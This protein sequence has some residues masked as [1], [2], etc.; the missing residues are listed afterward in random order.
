MDRT[1][2]NAIRFVMDECL[3]PLLRDSRWFMYPFYHL[4]YR[5][6]NVPQA[7]DFKTL[8][9]SWSQEEY[10]EFYASLDT[11]SRNRLTDLNR[12]S[13]ELIL[14]S[15]DPQARTL[16]DVGSGKG[17][18]L[19]SI[20]Q[21][22]PHLEL[23]GLDVTPSDRTDSYTYVR[24]HVED[25]PFEDDAFDVVT[26]SHTLEHILHVRRAAAE[27][28]RVARRQ[29]IV[30]TPCQR[31][32]YYTLDEHVN[33]FPFAASL[34]SVLDVRDHDLR[35]VRGDWVFLGRPTTPAST[36]RVEAGTG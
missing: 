19:R 31:Y 28:R 20:A 3:P 12:P 17:H 27:L 14:R 8:V 35:K 23:T 15:V 7:M 34:T 29:L 4:A 6:K 21:R 26:C 5:G 9:H 32:F 2:T 10:D 22:H 33:F 18:L 13:L 1:L 11:I 36:A 30:V 24:G 16:L 25:L